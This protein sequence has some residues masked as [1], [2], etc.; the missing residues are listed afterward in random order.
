MLETVSRA[1]NAMLDSGY[2]HSTQ[3]SLTVAG[4]TW[5]A[6]LRS[7]LATEAKSLSNLVKCNVDSN[8]LHVP[9]KNVAMCLGSDSFQRSNS[10]HGE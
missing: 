5:F 2:E 6:S 9:C 1:C 3:S 10:S 4:A 8:K 7:S